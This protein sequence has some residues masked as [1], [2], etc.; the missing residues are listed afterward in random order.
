M[1][2]ACPNINIHPARKI[3]GK[4]RTSMY[5]MDTFPAHATVGDSTS[6]T[7]DSYENA[8]RVR[9]GA[10]RAKRVAPKFGGL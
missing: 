1:M 9:C 4:D 5:H 3:N 10:M 6:S 2:D 7:G 8:T